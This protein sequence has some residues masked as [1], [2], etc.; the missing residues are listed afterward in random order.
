MRREESSQ[1][2]YIRETREVGQRPE[3]QVE[4]GRESRA[5]AAAGG[6]IWC[7]TRGGGRRRWGLGSEERSRWCV[8]RKER[9]KTREREE[10]KNRVRGGGCQRKRMRK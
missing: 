3:G 7:F 8:G 5:K 2:K 6:R 4:I 1:R 9:K 10:V